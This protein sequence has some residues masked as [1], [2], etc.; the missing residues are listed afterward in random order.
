LACF[1]AVQEPWWWRLVS[2]GAAAA[3][4]AL[5]RPTDSVLVLA[6]LFAVALVVTRL[7]R[8]K[9]LAV[10]AVGEVVGWLPW[11]IE[12]YLRFGGPWERLQAAETT[13]P[14]GLSL[15]ID[16]FLV[17]FRIIDG[18][19]LYCCSRGAL[20]FVAGDPGPISWPLTIWLAGV[21]IAAGLGVAVAASQGQLP[22]MMLVFLPAALMAGFY[23]LLPSFI[24]VRFVM[25]TFALLSL[26]IALALIYAMSRSRKTAAALTVGAL[27]G[28]I[29]P[30]LLLAEKRLDGW[31]R[32]R[33]PYIRAAAAVQ[34]LV[35]GRP[36]LVIG[37]PQQALGFYLGCD[38][39]AAGSTRRTPREV[40]EARA[41]GMFVLALLTSPPKPGSYMASWQQVP[42]P[43]LAPSFKVYI[44]QD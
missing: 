15:K 12:A 9:V 32:A 16:N 10:V 13:G 37:G 22:E 36:C 26:P 4:V 29:G 14:G 41:K 35:D 2:T 3:L 23:L 39:Q 27:L 8:L 42:V 11:I 30:M 43:G 18:V 24:T 21:V 7:R 5:V 44:P 6:P 38:A 1:R 28:H 17:Y 31:G 33:I 25:P 19:P 34:P 40:S 20:S